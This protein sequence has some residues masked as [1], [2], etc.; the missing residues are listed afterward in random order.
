MNELI[1][2]KYQMKL[3]A[4]VEKAIWEEYISY[5]S[6]KLYIEKWHLTDNDWNN[7]W[8]NFQIAIKE[9][10]EI[11]LTQTLHNIDG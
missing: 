8:E 7:N 9:K 6:V 3:I 4:E 11:D 1:S 5:K 10:G 2:P